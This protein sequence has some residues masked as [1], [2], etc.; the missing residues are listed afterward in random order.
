MRYLGSKRRNN[1]GFISTQDTIVAL[2]AL[3]GFATALA[4]QGRPSGSGDIVAASAALGGPVTLV[5]VA[6]DVSS[7]GGPAVGGPEI[8]MTSDNRDLVQAVDLYVDAASFSSDAAGVVPRL[9]QRDTFEIPVTLMGRPGATCFVSLSVSY[10]ADAAAAPLPEEA[11][12]EMGVKWTP[13]VL[14]AEEEGDGSAAVVDVGEGRRGRRAL[15]GSASA[16]AEG[17]IL[18]GGVGAATPASAPTVRTV[19]VCARPNDATNEGGTSQMVLARVALFSGFEVDWS[20]FACPPGGP[21]SRCETGDGPDE[22]VLYFDGLTKHECVEVPVVEAFVMKGRKAR[23]SRVFEYYNP[24]KGG[25]RTVGADASSAEGLPAKPGASSGLLYT[26]AFS[27]CQLWIFVRSWNQ[28][29]CAWCYSLREV[30]LRAGIE[31]AV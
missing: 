7:I 22:L 28:Y 2:D 19:E 1:G 31:R 8:I 9:A 13:Q 6:P 10:H 24:A 14:E 16:A 27:S 21:V 20:Q 18:Q 26:V 17:R 15:Q 29:Y 4:S 12:Y 25:L 23:T 30:S 3:A 5:T 11:A